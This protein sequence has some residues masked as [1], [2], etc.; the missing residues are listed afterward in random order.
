MAEPTTDN[1]PGTHDVFVGLGSNLGDREGNLQA[2]VGQLRAQDQIE[3][4]RESSLIETAPVDSPDGA[5]MFL[6]GVVW[7]RTALPPASVLEVL[8]E[9]ERS[10]GRDRANQPRNAPRT[11]DL[12]LLLYGQQIINQP[13][14]VV[15]HPRM[16]EREFV[17][18]PLLQIASTLTNPETGEPYATA[19]A[20]LKEKRSPASS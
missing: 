19:Y 10:M 1:V 6:N 14:L 2:A 17:L 18:W 16:H 12:D 7:L 8:L 15:P 3:V 11:L 9:I 20:Q 5:G 4:L 13:D